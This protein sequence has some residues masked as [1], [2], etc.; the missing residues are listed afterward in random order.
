ML[1][2]RIW[3]PFY[4]LVAIL[5]FQKKSKFVRT[6]HMNFHA[7]SGLCSSRNERVMLNFVIW[8]PF[9]FS[10]FL[11]ICTNFHKKSGLCISRNE[12][13]MLNLVF[14]PI[15]FHSVPCRTSCDQPTY[16]AARFAPAIN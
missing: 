7:K 3:R 2:F 5:F 12:R 11:K 13:V 8:R 9:C 6:I 4:I 14:G 10:N 16:G 1:N 15:P